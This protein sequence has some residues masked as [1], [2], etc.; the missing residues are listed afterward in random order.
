MTLL[1]RGLCIIER[2]RLIFTHF[3]IQAEFKINWFWLTHP[4]CWIKPV[5][6]V[7]MAFFFY[8][9][10]DLSVALGRVSHNADAKT[11][12][13]WHSK[14]QYGYQNCLKAHVSAGFFWLP[15][16]LADAYATCA[17]SCVFTALSRLGKL[18]EWPEFFELSWVLAAYPNCVAWGSEQ[19][20]IDRISHVTACSVRSLRL[21]FAHQT[22]AAS[23]QLDYFRNHKNGFSPHI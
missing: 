2:L 13:E 22:L 11:Q 3:H 7:I 16:H 15:A 21:Q 12:S 19:T 23:S 18:L 1:W 17:V 5:F 20:S 4:Y 8:V 10:L 9:H 14:S 6:A